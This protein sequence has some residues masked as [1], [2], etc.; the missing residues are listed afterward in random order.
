MIDCHAH[1][2]LESED[3]LA[4][5]LERAR[6]AGIYAIVNICTNPEELKRGLQIAKTTLEPKIF[7]AAST[8]P[9]DVIRAE[10]SFIKEI[11]ACHKSLIA[12]GETGLDYFYEHSPRSKQQ[13]SLHAYIELA[14]RVKLPLV[15]HCRDAFS[16]L[17]AIFDGYKTIPQVMLHCFTGSLE[18]AK[19]AQNRGFYI[20]FSGIVTFAK[21]QELQAVAPY[22]SSELL[23]LETDAP[24]LAP[25]S[26]RGK[27]NESSNIFETMRF[28]AALRKVTEEELIA[29]T[30]ANAKKL[31]CFL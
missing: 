10:P 21:S 8:T 19:Q 3:A 22:I 15:I 11:E 6:K 20:S 31:F 28:V 9:H 26:K 13:E 29:T 7:T 16:D 30:T 27:K 14:L 25:Q 17:F 12:I 23:L 1:L 24:F 2:C 5:Q 18:E 4:E